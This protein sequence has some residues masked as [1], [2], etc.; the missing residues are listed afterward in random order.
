MVTNELSSV[1]AR[2]SMALVFLYWETMLDATT[3]TPDTYRNFI[4]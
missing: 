3:F 1:N 4:D 2:N